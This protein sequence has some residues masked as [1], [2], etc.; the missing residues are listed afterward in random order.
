MYCGQ[1]FLDFESLEKTKI[2]NYWIIRIDCDTAK[3]YIK[4]NHYSHGC[5]NGPEP[6]YGLIDKG[7]LIG[8][9]MFATPCSEAVRE[10]IFGGRREGVCNRITQTSYKRLYAKK[11]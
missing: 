10:S 9:I 5:H 1:K 11:Y 2:N 3:R 4:Q 6:C 7:Q 8:V